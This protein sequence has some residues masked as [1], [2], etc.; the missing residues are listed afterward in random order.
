VFSRFPISLDD[1]EFWKT[2]ELHEF[3]LYTGVIVLKSNL[4]RKKNIIIFFSYLY[5]FEFCVQ[6]HFVIN[7]M[8]WPQNY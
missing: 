8:I 1:I 5:L 2:T 6:V 4:T 7:I 3:L